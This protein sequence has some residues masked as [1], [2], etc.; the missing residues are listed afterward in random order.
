MLL[1]EDEFI[2]DTMNNCRVKKKNLIVSRQKTHRQDYS[3]KKCLK[4]VYC[5]FVC[6]S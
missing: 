2:K 4:N 1:L 6:Y 5:L 3:S